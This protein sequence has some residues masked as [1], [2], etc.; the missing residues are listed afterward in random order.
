MSIDYNYYANPRKL[1]FTFDNILLPD[2]S[3]NEP[4]SHGFIRYRIK[5]LATLNV[6]DSIAN[7]V[8]IFF[9]FNPPVTTNQAITAI[10]DPTSVHDD[11][12][13]V[14]DVK[15]FPNPSGGKV[16][17]E[18]ELNE[19]GKV[20]F[21]VYNLFG[22]KIRLL[23]EGVL[24]H[25]QHQMNYDLSDLQSGV[26]AIRMQKGSEQLVRMVVITSEHK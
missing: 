19:S 13:N 12:N 14:A 10:V 15:V 8:D 7:H 20:A 3:T 1:S 17:I 11:G 6:G 18:F 21:E 4:E 25:G 16:G 22:Q 24:N 2:S 26:Y 5:P 9:D 23:Y